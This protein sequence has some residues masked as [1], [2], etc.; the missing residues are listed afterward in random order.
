VIYSYLKRHLKMPESV[1]AQGC[2]FNHQNFSIH[3]FLGPWL[4]IQPVDRLIRGA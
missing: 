4:S 1:V 3:G 2:R